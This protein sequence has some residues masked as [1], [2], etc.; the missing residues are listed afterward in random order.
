MTLLSSVVV[1][2]SSATGGCDVTTSDVNELSADSWLSDKLISFCVRSVDGA[3]A[4]S[5]LIVSA[6]CSQ[7]AWNKGVRCDRIADDFIMTHFYEHH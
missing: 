1:H 2:T 3:T 4:F 5:G 6:M 7:C